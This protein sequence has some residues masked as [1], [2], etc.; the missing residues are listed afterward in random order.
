M[1]HLFKYRVYKGLNTIILFIVSWINVLGQTNLQKDVIIYGATASGVTAAIAAAREGVSVLLIEPGKN[2]GGMVTGG[3]SHTDYGDRTVIG[4][5]TTEFFQKIADH[6]KTHV[7]YWRGA[8]PHVGEKI[9]KDWLE[10][11]GIQVIYD[12]RVIHVHKENNSISKIILSDNSQVSGKVFIDAGYEG[13]LM[14][15]AGITYVV[16]REGIKDYNE[17]WAGRQPIT[18]TSHQ[19]DARVSPLW[20]EK[21]R[22]ILPLVHPKPMVGIG[23]GDD[24]VQSYC[25]RLIATDRPDNMIP[26]SKP[27]NYDP[28]IYELARRYYKEKPEAGPLDRFLANTSQRQ[29]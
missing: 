8:E 12:K 4:G 23:E 2:I 25:F 13:D 1:K 15:K 18:F 20:D 6:Y 3:L 9:L 24:G 5:L 27:E 16:G 29:V 14:A 10:E 11:Y 28:K 7:F 19:I 17:S 26:W 22:K 21:E